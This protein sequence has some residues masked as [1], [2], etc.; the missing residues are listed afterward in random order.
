MTADL[1]MPVV[2]LDAIIGMLAFGIAMSAIRLY[3]GPSLADRVVAL[4]LIATLSVG[5]IAIYSVKTSMPVLLLVAIVLALIMFLGTIAF[6]LYIQ[7][8]APP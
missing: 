5:M 8:G 6:A 7:K 4:D 3:L 2:L 1:T